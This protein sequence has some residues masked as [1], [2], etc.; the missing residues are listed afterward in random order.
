MRISDWSSDVCSSDLNVAISGHRAAVRPLLTA[1]AEAIAMCANLDQRFEKLC[2]QLDKSD[3]A[4]AQALRSTALFEVRQRHTDLI[5]QMAVSQ[6]SYSILGLIG[7]K[8]NDLNKGIDTASST[9]FP[10]QKN[11]VK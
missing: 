9:T 6:Q 10:T 3:A 5:T 2:S 4:K 8:N 7:T 11:V 1:L